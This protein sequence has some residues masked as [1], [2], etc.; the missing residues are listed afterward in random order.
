MNTTLRSKWYFLHFFPHTLVG[1][2]HLCRNPS[3]CRQCA[4]KDLR[5]STDYVQGLTSGVALNLSD[6]IEYYSPSRSLAKGPDTLLPSPCV[7]SENLHQYIH[8]L[9]SD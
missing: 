9:A 3:G 2:F 8:P 5:L 6:Q 4:V 7:F 1:L